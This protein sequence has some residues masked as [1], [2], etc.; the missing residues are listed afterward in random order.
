MS[1]LTL[2]PTSYHVFNEF[3]NFGLL[4]GLPRIEDETNAE[5]KKRLLDVFVHRSDSTYLGL[6]FGITRELGLS[7][8]QIGTISTLLDSNDV[9]LASNPAIVF[10]NT[11]CYIYSD[12]ANSTLIATLDRFDQNGDYYTLT[13]LAD[14]I[15]TTGYFTFT[16]NSGI[17]GAERSMTIFNQETI[18]YVNG[19][20]ID[21]A[22]NKIPLE[23]PY[24][25][26]GSISVLSNNLTERV[27]SLGALLK[28]NQYYIDLTGG[29]ITTL[30]SP[31]LGS[32]IRYQ[33][34]K[35]TF[36]VF[37][38][39]VI[40]HNFQS[41]DFKTK[42]FEQITDP[43]DGTVTNGAPTG[44]GAYLIN[45]LLSCYPYLFGA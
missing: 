11:K 15:N 19:E 38:S 45:E 27:M 25:M 12:Y 7:L 10:K 2:T 31:S 30:T 29:T 32:T 44:L 6:I 22:A 1:T 3:D 41:D 33:Y 35:T 23:N 42:M 34:Q 8:K 9:P 36:T 5:Y 17:D 14:Y 13:E 24:L 28:T 39:P 40:I 20:R 4:I 26:E 21:I 37:N 16:L 18:G 43:V